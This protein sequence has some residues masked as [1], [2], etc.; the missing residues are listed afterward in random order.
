MSNPSE[1]DLEYDVIEQLQL[2]GWEYSLGDH[3]V[4]H[5]KSLQRK[6]LSDVLLKGYLKEA[7]DRLNPG[8]SEIVKQEAITKLTGFTGDDLA[9]INAQFHTLLTDGVTV[10]TTVDGAERG[11][12]VKLV[13]FDTPTNNHFLA[14][15]QFEIKESF[16]KRIPDL[17]L[18]V[19]GIP[20]VV[21]ELKNPVN[22]NTGVDEAYNQIQTYKKEI[23]SLFHYNG[24]VVI[25]DGYDARAGSVTAGMSRMSAWKSK[26]GIH[27]AGTQDMMIDIMVEGMLNPTTLLDLIHSFTV[28]EKDKSI[29]PDT[30]ITTIHTIKKVAAYHQYYAVNFALQRTI[31]ASAEG[32]DRKGGV[33]WHT[34]GSGKSLSMLFYSGKVIRA[35][36]N[37]TIIVITDRNDLDDQLFTTFGSAK[38]LLRQTPTQAESRSDLKEKLSVASGG[39]VFTTIQKFWPEEG[40]TFDALTERSNVVV[41]ADEAHRTQYGFAPKTVDEKDDKGNVIGKKMVYGFAKYMRDALPNATYLGFTGTP[42]EKEDANTPAVFGDYVDIYDIQQAIHDGA[43]VPIYYESR[44]AKVKLSAEGEELLKELEEELLQEDQT[45]AQKAKGR[46][47]RLEAVVGAEERVKTVAEDII[48][49]Y[50]QRDTTNLGKAM[51]VAMSRAIAV[52][53]YEAIIALRPDWHNEDIDKGAIK[54]IMTS[55]ASDGPEM[56]KHSTTKEQ[57]KEIAL[58]VKD[59]NDPLKIVIVR[60]MWLT[61]FDAPCLHTLYIDKPMKGHNLMQAIARVN[62]VFR[63]K[64][65]GLVVDYLGI[66]TDLKN[67]LRFYSDSG[68]KGNPAEGQEQAVQLLLE[69]V[70][71]IDHMF[72]EEPVT[73]YSEQFQNIIDDP[74]VTYVSRTKGVNYDN[75]DTYSPRIKM[76]TILA[77]QEHVLCLEDGKKRFLREV[78]AMSKAFSIA[79]PH[80]DAQA[81]K[82]KVGFFQAVKAAMVKTSGGG[83]KTSG[84]LEL[85]IKQVIDES[86]VSEGIVNVFDAA[87]MSSPDISILSEDFLKDM[88]K[89]EYQNV[90]LETLRRLLNEEIKVM[91]RTNLVQSKTLREMLESTMLKYQNRSISSAEALQE[92]INMAKD[93][94]RRKSRGEELGLTEYE[95]AFYDALA[96]NESAVKELGQDTLTELAKIIV[97][98]IKENATIDWTIREQIQ[99]KMRRAVKRVLRETGYPPDAQKLAE[100]RVMETA[101]AIAGELI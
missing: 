95:V 51:V 82:S 73:P 49:H 50:E 48:N 98:V 67:A 65:A 62:R 27:R 8:V 28:F 55:S 29:D 14:V 88:Q 57:K 75:Y 66:A 54:V 35:L 33:V 64:A 32:G 99:A 7:V 83:G 1:G 38:N 23:P 101:N 25:S 91:S 71:V 11:V 78:I 79:M 96:E 36:N 59:P 19:N 9:S 24:V 97:G 6:K 31:S 47:A 30:G 86:I 37:P 43:T 10:N 17:I 18:F 84:E 60:D 46:Y 74:A 3:Y 94:K 16:G 70:D 93:L 77:A 89:S 41:I 21:M 52:R 12:I 5:P 56:V 68:G 53:L 2:Q 81:L 61:G 69:K 20:L 72:L 90:A 39:V 4:P 26:D 76:K 45:Q 100:L 40:N 58:R 92:L 80:E 22:E 15:N 85:A 34:Q 63:D 13:D 44:L 42:V 87:G